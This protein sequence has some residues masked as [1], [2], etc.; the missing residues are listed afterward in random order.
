MSEEL[1]VKFEQILNEPE[2]FTL[3]GLLKSDTMLAMELAYRLDRDEP[4]KQNK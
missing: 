3:N 2:F 4:K 1:K